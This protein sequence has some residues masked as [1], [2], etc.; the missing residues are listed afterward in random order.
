MRLRLTLAAA[1]VA[2]LPGV[3]PAQQL[4]P[5]AYAQSPVDAN[6]AGIGYGYSSGEI[7]F[8]PSLPVT[9]ARAYINAMSFGY[10]HTFGFLGMQGLVTAG[11]PYAWGTL[12][13]QVA[14]Q[15]SMVTRSG[16]GDTQVKLSLDFIGSPALSQ[17]A[18]AKAP[19]QPFVFGGSLLVDIPTGQYY[20]SKLI[21]IG[22]NRW[23]FKPEL[24]ISY[25]VDRKLYLDLYSGVWL[26]ADN[27]SFYK[28]ANVESQAV[29]SS[30]QLHVSYTFDPRFWLAVDGT[31]YSGGATSVNG[32]SSMARQDNTRV[33]V[34][35]AFKITNAQ[36]IKATF[37]AGATARVGQN[38]DTYGL[39]YQYLWF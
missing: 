18:F 4:E 9:N 15:D 28:G 36:S 1:L 23:A 27:P 39:A 19:Q 32:G 10:G 30:T 17:Q 6:F 11:I 8:D 13:G 37:S 24:G 14:A 26:F 16:L 7:L 22:T 38:F 12:K 3:A 35:A 31:W 5:R 2:A 21:N 34:V 25:I 20:P 33:G 29:M